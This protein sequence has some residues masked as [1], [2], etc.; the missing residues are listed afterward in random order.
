LPRLSVEAFDAFALAACEGRG[1][2]FGASAG[3]PEAGAGNITTS[4]AFEI[5]VGVV[6]A[7]AGLCGLW[8]QKINTATTTTASAALAMT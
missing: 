1:S 4:G 5:A 7:A 2:G 3:I 6:N 8:G